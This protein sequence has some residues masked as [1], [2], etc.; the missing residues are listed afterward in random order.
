VL[1]AVER[2]EAELLAA[3]S[4]DPQWPFI[5]EWLAHYACDRGDVEHGLALLRRAQVTPGHPLLTLLHGLQPQKRTDLGRNDKCWCGSG[6]KYKACHLHREQLPLEE[7]AYWLHLKSTVA[8]YDNPQFAEQ[9]VEAAK[10]LEG[11]P[12]A[13]QA[14]DIHPLAPDLVLFEGGAFDEF[15][16]RRGYLLPETSSG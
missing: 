2:A 8:L 10:I 11:R 9:V 4:L 12:N 15:V 13:P 16:A 3:D 1:G 7:R 14:E 5:P 6:R